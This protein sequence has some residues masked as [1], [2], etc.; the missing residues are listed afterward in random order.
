MVNAHSSPGND[1]EWRKAVGLNL[2]QASLAAVEP[3]AAV[4]AHLRLTDS[5]LEVDRQT[6][7]LRRFSHIY[8]VGGGK[9]TAPM[10]QAVE[11]ILGDRITAGVVSVK[12]GY[13]APTRHIR[14][15]QAGHPIPDE[16]GVR[17]TEQMLDLLRQAGPDD[18][19]I[20]LISGGGSALLVAPVPG[21]PLTDERRLTNALL[22]SGATINE[23]N[24][25]RKHLTRIKGGGLVRE[26]APATVISL[27]LSDVLGDPLEV[28]AS[29]PTVP[30]TTTFADAWRV[31][32]DY[33]LIDDLSP[34]IRQ[35]LEDGLAGRIPDTPKP[36][37]PIFER[38][39]NV[40]IAS[41]RRAVQAAVDQAARDGL[42]TLLLSTF[43]QGEARV[44]AQVFAGIGRELHHSNHPIPRPAAIIA[45]GET[46]VT[47]KGQG[48]GGRNQ[49]FA[50]AAAIHLDG[51]DNVTIVAFATDGSDGPTDAAGAIVDGTTVQRA[52]AIG[53]DPRKALADN[54]SYAFFQKLG[55]LIVTGPTNTNVDDL[56]MIIAS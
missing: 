38:T 15:E 30:D 2:V 47:V 28:I 51:I 53:L 52:R 50:L 43:I 17:A 10:A 3:A 25:V 5:W 20:C 8:V 55:D 33:G 31:L 21:I 4:R 23:I 37:D 1:R 44:V 39:Q 29:G 18:L 49:E 13:T 14:I 7:D 11:S 54:D 34:A 32:D 42:N 12:Y 56:Y 40:V 27:I 9:A 22:R 24:T 41:N 45:G 16:R 48:R 36:G 19:V 46:T 26:A 35:R 6:Y